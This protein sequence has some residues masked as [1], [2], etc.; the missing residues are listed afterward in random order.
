MVLSHV[1]CLSSH[2][3]LLL[4][5]IGGVVMSWRPNGLDRALRVRSWSVQCDCASLRSCSCGDSRQVKTTGRSSINITDLNN[6]RLSYRLRDKFIDSGKDRVSE[7][8]LVDWNNHGLRHT[9]E[10]WAGNSA[11]SLVRIGRWMGLPTTKEVNEERITPVV[12]N[13]VAIMVLGLV[14]EILNGQ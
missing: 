4:R 7:V 1:N 8:L 11:F 2:E 6:I 3:M 10:F 9:D 12:A 5:T 13:F 14:F